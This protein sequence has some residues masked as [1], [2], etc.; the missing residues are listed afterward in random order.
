MKRF[1]LFLILFIT[2]LT[3]SV[4]AGSTVPF[5]IEAYGIVIGTFLFI[6]IVLIEALFIYFLI[7]RF[8]KFKIS[9]LRAILISLLA[10]I[11]STIFGFFISFLNFIVFLPLMLIPFTKPIAWSIF[12]PDNA[13]SLFLSLFIAYVTTSLV[14]TPVLHRFIRNKTKKTLIDS[15]KI[16]FLVNASSYLPIFIILVTWYPV[17]YAPYQGGVVITDFAELQPLGWTVYKSD[18][19]FE[20]TFT[21]TVGTSFPSLGTSIEITN[22]TVTD[23]LDPAVV[24][25]DPL[26]NGVNPSTS[27][28]TVK[29]RDSFK[30]T[31]VE[32]NRVRNARDPFD[33]EITITY[34]TIVHGIKTTHIDVGR[35]RGPVED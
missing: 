19:S 31:A 33:L 16:S 8:F 30:L 14:E 22:A 2:L 15:G 11:C 4:V 26:I 3:T 20:T 35:I 18:G 34:T 13:L 21:N 29:A 32:V 1:F 17:T 28:Q 5:L 6:P 23:K 7:K 10:N 24:W 27:P 12:D 9:F 25:S